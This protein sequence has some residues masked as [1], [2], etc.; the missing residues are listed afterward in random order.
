[1]AGA[2]DPGIIAATIASRSGIS[3]E[4]RQLLEES[5]RMYKSCLA[6]RAKADRR[7][8]QIQRVHDERSK[9]HAPNDPVLEEATEINVQHMALGHTYQNLGCALNELGEGQKSEAMLRTALRI[10]NA[11]VGADSTLVAD[12]HY[13]LGL[14]LRKQGR[15]RIDEAMDHL[16]E[17]LRIRVEVNGELHAE[18]GETRNSLA[19]VLQQYSDSKRLREALAHFKAALTIL[20]QTIGSAEEKGAE[21]KGEPPHESVAQLHMRIAVV[22][23]K[24]WHYHEAPKG[25]RARKQEEAHLQV[26]D[27]YKAAL[28]IRKK[29]YGEEEPKVGHCYQ[30]LAQMQEEMGGGHKEAALETYTAALR[31]FIKVAMPGAAYPSLS[32]AVENYVTALSLRT[33]ALGFEHVK[34]G[35]LFN[36]VGV[37]LRELGRLDE[38]MH[39]LDTALRIRIKTLGAEHAKVGDTY[40][41]MG[42]M[43][44]YQHRL[45]ESMVMHK[46]ALRIRVAAQGKDHADVGNTYMNMAVLFREQ[47]NLDRA[48]DMHRK[49]LGTDLGGQSEETDT[50]GVSLHLHLRC[51]SQPVVA[52]ATAATAVAA[53][54]PTKP[55]TPPP[56]KRKH[57]KHKHTHR[58]V[59]NREV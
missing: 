20:L 52:A 50:P 48:M 59:G 24:I 17:A 58:V 16:R 22:L 55:E 13:Q 44:R 4:K 42:I 26:L 30:H 47:G 14:G 43:R 51:L 1:M 9:K 57:H 35:D 34:V 39:M 19:M 31:I 45:G 15:H 6:I 11:A 28:Q 54:I 10:R 21:E 7:S 18:V 41:E 8:S 29:V 5:V 2:G 36:C 56:P 25:R 27:H 23:R 53:F 33:A 38:G 3:N 32:G 49:A 12:S 37:V 40:S 46:T